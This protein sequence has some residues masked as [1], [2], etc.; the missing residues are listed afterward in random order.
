MAVAAQQSSLAGVGHW[1]NRVLTQADC[2]LL[3]EIPF[4]SRS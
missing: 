4:D 3:F 1:S 2:L